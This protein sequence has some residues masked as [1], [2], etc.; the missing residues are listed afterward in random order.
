[1]Q[2]PGG[3]SSSGGD[4]LDILSSLPPRLLTLP[5]IMLTERSTLKGMWLSAERGSW[6]S[7]LHCG[8]E[9]MLIPQQGESVISELLLLLLL[10]LNLE[11]G[12]VT[13]QRE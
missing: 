4:T 9:A 1:M 3:G 13:G 11:L 8:L 7:L 5:S 2:R 10:L 12:R 6:L